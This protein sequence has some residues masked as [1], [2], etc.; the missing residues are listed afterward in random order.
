MEF[1]WVDERDV[2]DTVEEMIR[3]VFREVMQVELAADSRA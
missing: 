2:Q 3:D 1:A